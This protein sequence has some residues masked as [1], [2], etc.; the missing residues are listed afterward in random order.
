MSAKA[1]RKVPCDA[2]GRASWI[3]LGRAARRKAQRSVE[4]TIQ[5]AEWKAGR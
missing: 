4:A 2:N 5:R 1:A 3:R